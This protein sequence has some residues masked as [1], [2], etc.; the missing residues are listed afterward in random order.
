MQACQEQKTA[1]VHGEAFT[2]WPAD[3]FIPPD[4]L[5][6]LLESFSG[7]L[8]L[9]LYL[10]RKQNMDILD[11]PIV[12]I[13]KQYLHYIELMEAGRISL[14]A[15][16]LVMAAMLAEI[17]SRCLLPII[18]S[19]TGE[20]EDPRMEL[21]RRLQLY[22]SIQAASQALDALPRLERDNFVLALPSESQK[23]ITLHPEVSFTALIEAMQGLL[24]REDLL[25]HHEIVAE[26]LSVRARMTAILDVL[27]TKKS[28]LFTDIFSPEEG[29]SGIVVSFLA[30]L[31]LARQSLIKIT[32]VQSWL[33]IYIEGIDD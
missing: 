31:E 22:E 8:D 11:I 6:V 19:D 3:L 12:T 29:A 1:Q 16:Y 10:I 7:P 28:L 33:P 14:A 32:Q 23:T 17:K 9:L 20:E 18:Q 2:Q 15:D 21:V 27:A 30:L 4:A 26:P 13:T 25:Q 24:L 5:E